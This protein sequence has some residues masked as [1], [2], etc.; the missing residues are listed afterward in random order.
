[1]KGDSNGWGCQSK[2]V[3]DNGWGGSKRNE[4]SEEAWGSVSLPSGTP[5]ST[6]TSAS[7]GGANGRVR[8]SSESTASSHVHLPLESS[9]NVSALSEELICKMVE[10]LCARFCCFAD[11]VNGKPGPN[12]IAMSELDAFG[13]MSKV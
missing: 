3:D 1:M 9:V 13:C 5:S 7:D 2:E 12:V 10:S 4:T 6:T 8:S 11:P